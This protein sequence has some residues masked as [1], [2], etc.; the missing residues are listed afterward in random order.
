MIKWKN[1]CTKINYQ[2]KH[3]AESSREWL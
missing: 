1:R 2:I 3:L